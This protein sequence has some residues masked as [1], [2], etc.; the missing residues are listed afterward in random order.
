METGRRPSLPTVV[1]ALVPTLA[2]VGV[3]PHDG[4]PA[5]VTGKGS[6]V[7]HAGATARGAV[8]PD[9]LD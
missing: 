5:L 7:D 1:P 2:P 8:L 4:A 9:E 6:V 3:P